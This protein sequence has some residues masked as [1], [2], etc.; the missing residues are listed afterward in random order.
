MRNL[1]LNNRLRAALQSHIGQT[2]NHRGASCRV[3]ELLENEPA[4][5]LEVCHARSSLQETQYGD[6]GRR[7]AE[8]VTIPLFA[9][10]GSAALHPE[11]L[12]LGLLSGE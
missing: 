3:V 12:R 4:L 1:T 10:P 9:E 11:L 6:P 8:I 2:V 5:V 7:V